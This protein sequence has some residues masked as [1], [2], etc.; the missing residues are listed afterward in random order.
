M[1]ALT[2]DT[3]QTIQSAAKLLCGYRRR[4][5]QAEM[6]LKYCNG[7]APRRDRL[8]LGTRRSRDGA[9]R[10]PDRH[11]LPG[12]RQPPR[13]EEDR[14]TLSE[15]RRP[16]PPP[17]RPAGPSRS[18]VPDHPGVH[19]GH[20]QGRSGSPASRARVAG[21]RPLPPDRRP[22]PQPFWLPAPTGPQSP[23]RKKIPETDAIFANV[24]AARARAAGDPETLRIS[25]DTKAKVKVGEF[26]RGGRARGQAGEG[27][28]PRHVSRGHAGPVG[29]AG[30]KSR[31][32]GGQP[33]VVP[34]RT[35]ARDQRLHRRRPR[36]MV[37]RASSGPP[38]R[39]ATAHRTRQ[40][41]GGRQ[42]SDAV[43]EADGGVRRPPLGGGRTG[44]PAALP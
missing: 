29:S 2:E 25:L 44:V 26:C 27:A 9:Q 20:G 4:Q 43:H 10:K 33:A 8:R 15:A 18:Q 39:P 3:L 24:H 32:G 19:P 22:D 38:R 23:A 30:G 11:P 5:F 12:R 34:L 13:A 6:A 21:L 31:Q 41:S 40:R 36:T 7:S 17:G 42:L 37:D 16:H 35:F 14:R 28:R 1:A